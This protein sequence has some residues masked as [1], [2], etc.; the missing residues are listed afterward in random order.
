MVVV[1]VE[2]MVE[3]KGEETGEDLA[4]KEEGKEEAKVV[5]TGGTEV[6]PKKRPQ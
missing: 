4:G 5:E 6:A 2:E 3:E 1:K